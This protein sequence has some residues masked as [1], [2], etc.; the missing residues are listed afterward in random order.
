MRNKIAAL[1]SE[2]FRNEVKKHYKKGKYVP[3][4]VKHYNDIVDAPDYRMSLTVENFTEEN[5]KKIYSSISNSNAP[6]II[7]FDSN[8]NG[9]MYNPNE[10][11]IF[12]DIE[13]DID[14]K[15]YSSNN[16]EFLPVLIKYNEVTSNH[17][18]FDIAPIDFEKYSQ[19]P[20]LDTDFEKSFKKS[21][22]D[23]F[24]AFIYSKTIGKTII[25]DDQKGANASFVSIVFS[26]LNLAME[27]HGKLDNVQEVE[28]TSW[29]NIYLMFAWAMGKEAMKTFNVIRKAQLPD[30]DYYMEQYAAFA[31]EIKEFLNTKDLNALDQLPCHQKFDRLD[32]PFKR[33]KPY[34]GPEGPFRIFDEDIDLTTDKVPQPIVLQPG[35]QPQQPPQPDSPPKTTS[36]TSFAIGASI[37]TI[38]LSLLLGGITTGICFGLKNQLEETILQTAQAKVLM[39]VSIFVVTGIISTAIFTYVYNQHISGNERT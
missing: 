36:A 3:F 24:T 23:I 17:L 27:S 33:V 25:I 13:I 35:K 34:D 4:A 29:E 5:T 22:D 11:T 2:K 28:N 14:E 30:F 15:I 10:K 38:T 18:H 32:I 12:K 21:L 39:G 8:E 6:F 1:I 9:L 31:L 16:K 19:Q 7:S 37:I 26:M 20:L